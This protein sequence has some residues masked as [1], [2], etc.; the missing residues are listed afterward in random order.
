MLI[1]HFA[2]LLISNHLSRSFLLSLLYDVV[3]LLSRQI[4]SYLSPWFLIQPCM[5]FFF[6]SHSFRT[7]LKFTRFYIHFN[8]FLLWLNFPTMPCISGC[9]IS[10][11]EK[12]NILTFFFLFSLNILPV[13]PFSVI[14]TFSYN[15][16]YTHFT[17]SFLSADKYLSL[18]LNF[19]IFFYLRFFISFLSLS[20]LL[21][22]SFQ[23]YFNIL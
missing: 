5:E 17:L 19:C 14:Q 15:L 9:S 16:I 6:R 7:F 21:C 3:S 18:F 12:N 8:L 10:N 4:S 11:D 13:Y 22:H 20:H 23:L 2:Y 1:L